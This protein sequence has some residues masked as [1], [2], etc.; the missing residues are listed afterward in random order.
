VNPKSS[1][2][3]FLGF[4]LVSIVTFSV[5]T[6]NKVYADEPDFPIAVTVDP[7][8]NV[9]VIV[10]VFGEPENDRVIKYT[11]TGNFITEWGD[12]SGDGEF[13][14]AGNIAADNSGNVFVT[15]T[16]SIQKFTNTGKFIKKWGGKFENPQGIAVDPSG[17]VFIADFENGNIQKFTNDGKFIKKWGIGGREDPLG[18]AVDPSNGNVFVITEFNTIQKFTNDGK[19]IREW[20]KHD[21]VKDELFGLSGIA[22]GK[23]G[24]VFVVDSG[25]SRNHIQKYSNTG[26]FIRQWGSEGSGDGQFNDAG[27]VAT[28]PSGNVFVTDFDNNRIQ[29]FSNT[30]KFI[31]KWVTST[32][33]N[34]PLPLSLS[35]P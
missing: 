19:F 35:L 9:F 5:F 16:N 20:K 2:L 4:V 17:N 21:F 33:A 34:S 12:G 1:I 29:K 10:R 15:D 23:S 14:S 30:G 13:V 18:I 26:K 28:D 22:V 25:F 3:V 7:S 11:N 32:E 6:S 31:R 27:D 8:G 24:N